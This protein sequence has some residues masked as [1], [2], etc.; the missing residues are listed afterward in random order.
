MMERLLFNADEEE[1]EEEEYANK[2]LLCLYPNDEIEN[3]KKELTELNGSIVY[4][5][6]WDSRILLIES[7]EKK[8]KILLH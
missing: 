5:I 6:N 8:K 7:N 2:V 1:E 4:Y 3:L